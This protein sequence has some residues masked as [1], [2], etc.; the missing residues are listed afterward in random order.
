MVTHIELGSNAYGSETK[1]RA[2]RMIS[3]RASTSADGAA[4]ATYFF[5][6]FPE[7]RPVGPFNDPRNSAIVRFRLEGSDKTGISYV[8]GRNISSEAVDEIKREYHGMRPERRKKKNRRGGQRVMTPKGYENT[9]NESPCSRK[10]DFSQETSDASV[11]T[12]LAPSAMNVRSDG[13]VGSVQPLLSQISNQELPQVT[14]IDLLVD[15]QISDHYLTEHQKEIFLQHVAPFRNLQNDKM[16]TISEIAYLK[17]CEFLLDRLYPIS[18]NKEEASSFQTEPGNSLE[19][20]KNSESIEEVKKSVKELAERVPR[21][22]AEIKR[23]IADMTSNSTDSA[24][25]NLLSFA[26]NTLEHVNFLRSLANKPPLANLY[27]LLNGAES[28]HNDISRLYKEE[29]TLY[30]LAESLKRRGYSVRSPGEVIDELRKDLNEEKRQRL[31]LEVRVRSLET[32]NHQAR[33]VD[34][35]PLILGVVPTLSILVILALKRL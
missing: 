10:D 11:Q 20:T 26:Q 4:E 25:S 24:D 34:W 12:P 19:K 32:S 14:A 23:M 6:T 1:L 31:E 28:D 16:T 13:P 27:E 15:K 2:G 21:E 3:S 9:N 17:Y 35:V 8:V 7:L 22:S 29:E 33:K 5:R 18:P 30:K